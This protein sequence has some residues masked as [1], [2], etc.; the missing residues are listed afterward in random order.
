MAWAIWHWP[1]YFIATNYQQ[2]IWAIAAAIPM[3]MAASI[4]YTWVFNSAGGSLFAVVVLHGVTVSVPN[5]A[6]ASYAEVAPLQRVIVPF[7]YA[8]IAIGLVWRYG[9]ADLAWRGR[10]KASPPDE[11]VTSIGDA[12]AVLESSSG[13]SRTEDLM[14]PG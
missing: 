4:L 13:T 5:L 2:P 10:V 12:S 6:P 1:N 14:L 7:L 3:G 9:A 11:S 8:I